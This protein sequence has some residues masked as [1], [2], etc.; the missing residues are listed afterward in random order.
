MHL[1]SHCFIFL[2]K[3]TQ[4]SNTQTVSLLCVNAF[5]GVSN[6]RGMGEQSLH[7]A[8][9]YLQSLKHFIQ[10]TSY[11]PVLNHDSANEEQPGLKNNVILLSG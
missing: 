11:H 7:V 4:L 2:T 9:R 5:A 3:K 8:I 1:W 10:E 6:S